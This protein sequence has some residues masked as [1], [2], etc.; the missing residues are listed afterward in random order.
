MIIDVSLLIK[1]ETEEIIGTEE[2][3]GFNIYEDVKV[4][5]PIKLRTSAVFKHGLLKIELDIV[6]STINTCS[7]CLKEYKTDQKLKFKEEYTI[8]QLGGLYPQAIVDSIQ[9]AK[10]LMILKAPVK[11]LCK[12]DC[13]GLCAVCGIDKNEH[14]CNCEN[15]MSNPHFDKLKILLSKQDKEV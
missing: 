2:V 10:E 6:Y 13:L 7:R 5:T 9:I 3:D 11:N 8:E 15:A 12:E 4:L 1:N 14:T